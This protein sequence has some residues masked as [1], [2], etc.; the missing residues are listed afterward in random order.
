MSWTRGW[1]GRFARLGLGL[2]LAACAAAPTVTPTAAPIPIA[3][4]ETALPL[5]RALAEA[6]RQAVPGA[7]LW[8]SLQPQAA[9]AGELAAGRA[10]LA[11]T[12]APEAGQ[13]VTPVG[14][15]EFA[16]VTQPANPVTAL[17]AAQAR[18]LF[19]G[20]I[21]DWGQAGGAPG[22]V[23]VGERAAGSDGALA[24]AQALEL[25]AGVNL[26]ALAA[27]TWAA[28]RAWVAET[29][30]AVGYLPVGELDDSVK[31]LSL[32]RPLTAAITAMAPAEPAG[33][34]RDFLAW[35]Q[36]PAAAQ[37]REAAP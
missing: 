1:L 31:A 18:A 23:Q 24:F 7:A 29:P 37:A 4:T 27:P 14:T 8:I 2:G 13:F 25:P 28:L 16:V 17:S 10:A 33:P 36:S 5:V 15:V 22:L 30:G 32:D 20:Q 35:A 3:A 6:Y 26:N 21:T 11:F 19:A 9:L 34:A 12:A